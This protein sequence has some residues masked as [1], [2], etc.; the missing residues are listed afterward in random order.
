MGQMAKDTS[1]S[2]VAHVLGLLTGFLGPLVM[3]L[4][5]KEN[6]FNRDQIIEAL[7]FQLTIIIGYLIS[8]VLMLVLI[9]F[10]LA[11]AVGIFSFIFCIIA[12]VESSKGNA[13]RYPF[14][15]RFIK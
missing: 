8:G 6:D 9:G 10:L 4:V 2:V 1:M 11:F 14:A 15:I 7:N 12:A 3:Y 5:Y 13:Y